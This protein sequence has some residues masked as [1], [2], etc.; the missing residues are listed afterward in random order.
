MTA[1]IEEN[2]RLTVA[3]IKAKSPVLAA[4]VSSGDLM[5]VGGVYNLGTGRVDWLDT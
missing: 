4:R 3:D 1:A 5:V 2:V